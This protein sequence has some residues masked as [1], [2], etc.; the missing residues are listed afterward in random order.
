MASSRRRCRACDRSPTYRHH[1]VPGEACVIWLCLD[2]HAR[3]EGFGP[4][5][6]PEDR[7]AYRQLLR[8]RWGL[9]HGDLP[10]GLR[11]AADGVSTEPDPYESSVVGRILFF[12]RQRLPSRWML[13]CLKVEGLRC[14]NGSTDWH[15]TTLRRIIARAAGG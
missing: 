14:R 10:Y 11:V 7:A 8:E 9:R 15:E 13:R 12:H 1:P 2:C 6:T 5:G 3:A 4:L